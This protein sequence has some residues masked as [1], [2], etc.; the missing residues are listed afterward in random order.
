MIFYWGSPTTIMCLGYTSNCRLKCLKWILIHHFKHL[1][2]SL[3]LFIQSFQFLAILLMKSFIRMLALDIFSL[4]MH[5]STLY[6]TYHDNIELLH[7]SVT[8]SNGVRVKV[9]HLLESDIR[10]TLEIWYYTISEVDQ[11]G[12]IHS[13]LNKIQKVSKF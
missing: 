9:S 13:Y 8:L 4:L 1:Q 3:T 12:N 10:I 7:Y 5:C 11:T 2:K 6:C